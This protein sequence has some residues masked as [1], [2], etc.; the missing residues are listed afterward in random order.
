M[1]IRVQF[2]GGKEPRYFEWLS[3]PGE[4]LNILHYVFYRSFQAI[5]PDENLGCYDGEIRSARLLHLAPDY[6]RIFGIF[7]I[8][9]VSV[10]L[11]GGFWLDAV[12]D[13]PFAGGRD[14]NFV[15]ALDL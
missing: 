3:V 7:G 1:I 10:L 11:V 2:Q 6:E 14:A 15:D 13:F 4:L 12:G 8:F 5:T 9:V